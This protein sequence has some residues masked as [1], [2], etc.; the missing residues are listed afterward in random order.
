M[1]S[2]QKFQCHSLALLVVLGIA[3]S[4]CALSAP[5]A[6]AATGTGSIE[7]EIAAEGGAPLAEA[8]ACAYLAKGE[9]FEE[10]CDFTGSDG[11][12]AIHGLQAGAYK[13]EF[14]PEATAPSYVG[15]YYNDKPYW[16]EADEVEV[17]EGVATAGIDAELAEGATIEGEVRAALFGGPLGDADAVV[18]ATFPTGQP[19]GCALTRPDGTYVLSGLPGGEYKIQFVPA[20]S[21]NLLNQFYDHQPEPAEA[22]ALKVAAGETKTGIDADLETGAEIHGTVYSAATEAPLSKVSV[23]ALFFETVLE[24]WWPRV[25][26]LSSSDGQYELYSLWAD[27]FKVVFSAD[28]NEIFGEGPHEE[29]GYFAQYFNGKSTLAAADPL[30]L[31]PPEVRT[32][33][34]GHLQSKPTASFP[35]TP[36]APPI[37]AIQGR[38][39]A[40]LRCRPG[41]RKRKVAG[42]RRCLKVHR[43]HH[44]KHRKS[45]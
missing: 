9:E 32:G 35:A 33:V 29:D 8:W 12:Y 20:F 2:P 3:L 4:V 38:R 26:V 24:A 6:G 17:E 31:T 1:L 36:I 45:V 15:E 7:G 37:A 5:A 23:C 39:E 41:F 16:E 10:N 44:R 14:W 43:R 30:A 40:P 34:D 22:D 11:I 42:K 28:F 13:V 25:C 18:C 19:G 27:N 21:S